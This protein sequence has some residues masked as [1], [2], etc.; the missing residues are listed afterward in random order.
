M[1]ELRRLWQ[2]RE[3]LW[4]LVL[5]DLKLRYK[6]SAIGFLWGLLNPLT[7]LAILAFVFTHIFA[8][9]RGADAPDALNYPLFLLGG[10]V[11]WTFIQQSIDRAASSVLNGIPLLRK[12][13]M[14]PALFPLASALSSLVNFLLSLPA[15]ALLAVLLRAPIG[16]GTLYFPIATLI[17]TTFLIGISLLVASLNVFF[18]DTTHL[19]QVLLAMAFYLTPIIYPIELIERAAPQVGLVLR[20]NPMTPLI[21]S[22]RAPVLDAALPSGP[23]LW[24]APLYALGALLLGWGAFRRTQDRFLFHA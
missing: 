19:V 13:A 17:L 4:L 3:L 21:E 1:K 12:V 18:R 9:P 5:T 6:G 8:N 11:A 23:A 20:W 16:W 22:V 15:L 24:I 14:P 2:Y 7:Q 10:L